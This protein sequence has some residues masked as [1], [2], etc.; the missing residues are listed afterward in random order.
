M[1][2]YLST[3]LPGDES[4]G[5]EAA[6]AHGS[7]STAVAKGYN[8]DDDIVCMGG[9]LSVASD[10]PHQREAC[11]VV[12]FCK[13]PP[14]LNL[15]CTATIQI[16]RQQA[17]AKAVTEQSLKNGRYCPMCYCYVCEIKAS[18]CLEWSAHR[19]ATYNDNRWKIER[20]ARNMKILQLLTAKSKARFFSRFKYILSNNTS[21]GSSS[22]GS[23]SLPVESTIDFDSDDDQDRDGDA[24]GIGASDKATS[25]IKSY[26]GSSSSSSSKKSSSSSSSKKKDLNSLDAVVSIIRS[27]LKKSKATTHPSPPRSKEELNDYYLQASALLIRIIINPTYVTTIRPF[28]ERLLLEW[29]FHP[30]NTNKIRNIVLEEIRSAS[31][32]NLAICSPPFKSLFRLLEMSDEQMSIFINPITVG[33]QNKIQEMPP[34]IKELS[35]PTFSTMFET[36]VQNSNNSAVKFLLKRSPHRVH[37]LITVLLQSGTLADSILAIKYLNAGNIDKFWIQQHKGLIEALPVK[38]ILFF[39]AAVISSVITSLPHRLVESHDD[40]IDVLFNILFIKSF[41]VAVD[42]YD[43]Q[44]EFLRSLGAIMNQQQSSSLIRFDGTNTKEADELK[45]MVKWVAADYEKHHESSL[46]PLLTSVYIKFTNWKISYV[47]MD[48]QMHATVAAKVIT[49][50]VY[51]NFTIRMLV[52]MSNAFSLY[53]TMP[54][55]EIITV[56]LRVSINSYLAMQLVSKALEKVSFMATSS[57]DFIPFLE[58]SI[59]SELTKIPV[60]SKSNYCVGT[61]NSS[62]LK[63]VQ[64]LLNTDIPTTGSNSSSDFGQLSSMSTEYFESSMAMSPARKMSR[65]SSAIS[66]YQQCRICY[67]SKHCSCDDMLRRLLCHHTGSIE[68]R[69]FLLSFGDRLDLQGLLGIMNMCDGT[70]KMEPSQSK[71]GRWVGFLEA[72]F[73]KLLIIWK[74]FLINFYMLTSGYS[75][76][77]QDK[78]TRFCSALVQYLGPYIVVDDG[79]D[80]HML[81]CDLI[82]AAIIGVDIQTAAELNAL[83]VLMKMLY[84]FASMIL[85]CKDNF[86]VHC[87]AALTSFQQRVLH[88]ERSLVLVHDVKYIVY[89]WCLLEIEEKKEMDDDTHRMWGKVWRLILNSIVF[90]QVYKDFGPRSNED[91]FAVAIVLEEWK[92]LCGELTDS[93]HSTKLLNGMAMVVHSTYTCTMNTSTIDGM[94]ILRDLLNDVCERNNLIS[95]ASTKC[96]NHPDSLLAHL[97]TDLPL[98]TIRSAAMDMQPFFA[99]LVH[100]KYLGV[101]KD[102]NAVLKLCD[103]EVMDCFLT[104]SRAYQDRVNNISLSSPPSNNESYANLLCCCAYLKQFDLVQFIISMGLP[105]ILGAGDDDLNPPDHLYDLEVELLK[106][107]LKFC[108]NE[109][110]FCNLSSI[111][112]PSLSQIYVEPDTPRRF[113]SLFDKFYSCSDKI[114]TVMN[115]RG[116]SSASTGSPSSVLALL[117]FFHLYNKDSFLLLWEIIKDSTTDKNSV[118]SFIASTETSTRFDTSISIL[119]RFYICTESEFISFLNT[120]CSTTPATCSSSSSSSSSSTVD[121]CSSSLYA[122]S[123]SISDL[124]EVMEHHT[125]SSLKVPPIGRLLI[126]I[127]KLLLQSKDFSVETKERI[128]SCDALNELSIDDT[129]TEWDESV[130]ILSPLE[131]RLLLQ[132]LKD[133][134]KS[135]YATMINL[136]GKPFFLSN[137]SK[138]LRLF[139]DDDVYQQHMI[140]IL[141]EYSFNHH[142]IIQKQTKDNFELLFHYIYEVHSNLGSNW[143]RRIPQ[144][145]VDLKRVVVSCLLSVR[146]EGFIYSDFMNPKSFITLF[147]KYLIFMKDCKCSE[148]G[149]DL[150]LG[151]DVYA[152]LPDAILPIVKQFPVEMPCLYDPALMQS[153]FNVHVSFTVMNLDRC[154]KAFESNALMASTAP[155]MLYNL[156]S[157]IIDNSSCFMMYIHILGHLLAYA[158]SAEGVIV[159][160]KLIQTGYMLD[161]LIQRLIIKQCRYYSEPIQ[162]IEVTENGLL[163]IPYTSAGRVLDY[164]MKKLCALLMRHKD[165]LAAPLVEP[166]ISRLQYGSVNYSLSLKN[167]DE[168]N[169]LSVEDQESMMSVSDWARHA[170]LMQE[171][172]STKTNGHLSCFKSLLNHMGRSDNKYGYL[173]LIDDIF[174]DF[175]ATGLS[176]KSLP[177]TLMQENSGY[178]DIL[179]RIFMKHVIENTI[180]LKDALRFIMMQNRHGHSSSSTE[181]SLVYFFSKYQRKIMILFL[182]QYKDNSVLR[183]ALLGTTYDYKLLLPVNH[184][185]NNPELLQLVSP[186]EDGQVG[187]SSFYYLNIAAALLPFWIDAS[188]TSLSESI[189]EMSLRYILLIV[190]ELKRSTVNAQ[191][192]SLFE[193]CIQSYVILLNFYLKAEGKDVVEK[194]TLKLNVLAELKKEAKMALKSKPALL[195]ILNNLPGFA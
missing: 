54:D 1:N 112:L 8:S 132:F 169:F 55:K 151:D 56:E 142:D 66:Q 88:Y 29:L 96:I 143:L 115:S 157:H 52:F 42:S 97:S 150:S 2:V 179:C 48:E 64:L 7:N 114:S 91:A 192:R 28:F 135:N 16:A 144:L 195:K 37:L 159:R 3:Y 125:H 180:V 193:R 138:L 186:P 49:P 117:H 167:P 141:C 127:C 12:P 82:S 39:L 63:E 34:Q 104:V 165:L 191:A 67:C 154:Y 153:F 177:P 32:R 24:A 33:H 128:R 134:N 27:Y 69:M 60:I 118:L 185:A 140:Q 46:V 155:V 50:A 4:G 94:K 31:N 122:K 83:D 86:G 72:N 136:L 162:S 184:Y 81:S 139:V 98:E 35:D 148:Y 44:I 76:V 103:M 87:Q 65:S 174:Q 23:S 26:K 147:A 90:D 113:K 77:W 188:S 120:I 160:N 189:F 156:I 62:C 101:S 45:I 187:H 19:N 108:S 100:R 58:P 111:L 131:A 6:A 178:K 137:Y 47:A 99:H 5:T 158:E 75:L 20:Q 18:E 9:N 123:S 110:E 161:T 194:I 71:E 15:N 10:M 43:A 175:S 126:T 129:S 130:D 106:N 173:Q 51:W 105:T 68:E 41:M 21:S 170:L 78:L 121:F 172:T 190:S 166:I 92:P 149:R 85:R 13:P 17:Y 93:V 183:V 102:S 164:I 70:V 119:G 80:L 30:F 79:S 145:L 107:V 181:S 89:R 59:I 74:S 171:K 53:I 84:D 176:S 95:F 182:K 73:N 116:D 11:S 57:A 14:G 38:N 124:F 109:Q 25:S 36:L 133:P 61:N 163:W 152:M 40:L 22:G 168:C 146:P